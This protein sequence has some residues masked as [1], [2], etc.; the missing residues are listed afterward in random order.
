MYQTVNYQ[1]NLLDALFF[2]PQIIIYN[3][4]QQQ[5]V[6]IQI[7]GSTHKLVW[8]IRGRWKLYASLLHLFLSFLFCFTFHVI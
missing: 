6:T 2:T 5:L 8:A 7:C 4:L 1:P 3:L